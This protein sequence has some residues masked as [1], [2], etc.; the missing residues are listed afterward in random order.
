MDARSAGAADGAR[1]A[2][3]AGEAEGANGARAATRA[4]GAK[5]AADVAPLHPRG[6]RG[7][8]LASVEGWA[9]VAAGLAWLAFASDGGVVRGLAAGG[10][11]CV[12]LGAGIGVL[13]YPGDLRIVSFGALASLA[14]LAVAALGA[15]A[16]G[17]ATSLGLVALAVVGWLASGRA[18]LAWTSPTPGV[19]ERE[20]SLRLASK[21]AMDEALLASF[22]LRLDFP[23]GA[24]LEQ[25]VRETLALRERHAALGSRE[26][27]LAVHRTPPPLDAPRLAPARAAGRDFEHLAFESEWEPQ[28]GEPGRERW[29]SHTANRTA[30]AYVVRSDPSAPWLVAI[31]GYRMGL[32]PIDLRL[33]DPRL[34]VDRMGLNLAIPVLPL[35]GPR[36][37]GRFSGDGYLDGDPVAFFHAECQAIWD[38]RRIVSWIR[39]QGGERI[40]V[41][42]LSLGGYNC[43]LLA[44]VE[45]GLACAIAGIPVA[46]FSRILWTHGPP[47]LMRAYEKAGLPREE[48]ASLLAPVAPLALD[49]RVPREG[50]AVFAGTGD[51]IVPPE[52]QRDLIAHWDPPARCWYQGGHVTFRLDPEVERL[53]RGVLAARLAPAASGAGAAA[54]RRVADA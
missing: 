52:H 5:R 13:L 41:L 53:V 38:L 46:D 54:P 12:T 36:R 10:V 37:I 4:P 44:S 47:W 2:R 8:G 24:R 49:P 45:E 35:H 9:L 3:R 28:V 19:P 25:I 16:F 39:A 21:V 11:G 26:N 18:S 42:G 22:H 20:D 33:F 17:F 31:N 1:V 23:T 48:I 30:H 29:L 14:G 34:Y 32:A 40:G 50:R 27:P 43:A 15:V 7:V 6:L 51:R